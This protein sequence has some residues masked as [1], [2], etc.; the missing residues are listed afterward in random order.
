MGPKF[1]IKDSIIVKCENFE[2][3]ILFL[4]VMKADMDVFKQCV[5]SCL[6]YQPTTLVA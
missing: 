5:V 6:N 2:S 4:T 1:L 3:V